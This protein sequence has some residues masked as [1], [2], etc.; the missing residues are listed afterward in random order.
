MKITRLKRDTQRVVNCDGKLVV[1]T[2]TKSGKIKL[3]Q[4]RTRKEFACDVRNVFVFAMR[5]M[6]EDER[7]RIAAEKQRKFDAAQQPLPF[8]EQVE[9]AAPEAQVNA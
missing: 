5:Q 6:Q 8:V 3:R 7:K 9:V 2:L 4:L 1:V